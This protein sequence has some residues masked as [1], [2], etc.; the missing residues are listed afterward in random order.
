MNSDLAIKIAG[1]VAPHRKMTERMVGAIPYTL[2]YETQQFKG[3]SEKASYISSIEKCIAKLV[4]KGARKRKDIGTYLGLNTEDDLEKDI[5]S[6]SIDSAKKHSLITS[7]ANEISLTPQGKQVAEGGE[8]VVQFNNDFSIQLVPRHLSFLSLNECKLAGKFL[9][10]IPKGYEPTG[11]SLEKI[12]EFADKQASHVHHSDSGLKLIEAHQTECLFYSYELYICFLQSVKDNSVRTL[13]YDE[14]LDTII[15]PLSALFDSDQVL[16]EE[17]LE[18]CLS[19]EVKAQEV[20][21]VESGEKT[22]EQKQAEASLIEKEEKGDKQSSPSKYPKPGTLMDSFQFER[23][24]QEIFKDHH[25][26]EIWLISPWIRDYAFLN[27]REPLIRSFLENGGAIFI[28]YSEPERLGEEMVDP[29]SKSVIKRLE[30]NYERFYVMQ[31][32]KFH[33]KN[34]I[35]YNNGETILYSGSFNVLSFSVSGNDKHY[36]MEDMM[37]ANEEESSKKRENY[38]R[39]FAAVYLKAAHDSA[40]D[41]GDYQQSDI[42]KLKYFMNLPFLDE[43]IEEVRVKLEK[44][45]QEENDSDKEKEVNVQ[46]PKTDE[47]DE[48]YV[49]S[50]KIIRKYAP[51]DIKRIKAILASLVF[52]YENTEEGEKKEWIRGR[53]IRFINNENNSRICRF[54]LR[55]DKEDRKKSIVAAVLD[56]VFYEFKGISLPGNTFKLLASKKENIN[57]REAGLTN[58]KYIINELIQAAIEELGIQPE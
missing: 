34:V 44:E 29:Q 12:K 48:N 37:V 14:K 45:K 58:A 5:L 53:I 32:P 35:E 11:L 9:N 2:Y 3:V 19:G 22:E 41:N 18:K 6:A 26:E 50:E 13:I 38:L 17:L 49:L 36:R 46:A 31:M 21:E 15:Q 16:K 20:K 7:Y 47:T 54:T 33:H 55:P 52:I 10:K 25:N 8:Y 24:L 51:T 23:Y 30:K 27:H 4:Y 40:K 56:N 1:A 39:D 57:Y 28:A 42:N 43:V